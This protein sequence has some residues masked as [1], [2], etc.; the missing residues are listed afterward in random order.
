MKSILSAAKSAFD[1][2]GNPKTKNVLLLVLA[3]ASAFG[4]LAPETATS[5]RDAV[6]GF[7]L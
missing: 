2:L 5:L 4:V 7:V 1:L 6:T 3:L